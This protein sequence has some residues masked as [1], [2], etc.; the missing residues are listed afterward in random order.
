MTNEER[1]EIIQDVINEI[2]TQ[3]TSIDELPP[4][5]SISN[6]ESLPAYKRG[7][8]ELV[9]VPLSLISKPAV[10]AAASATQ[11]AE[12]ATL[13]KQEADAASKEA[14]EATEA[15][16]EATE[17]AIEASRTV[18]E[19]IETITRIETTA[20]SAKATADDNSEKLGGLSLLPISEEDYGNL[21]NEEKLDT[22]LF[23]C[24]EEEEQ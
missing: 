4:A 17:T 11:A 2:V 24:Y 20:N 1:Q 6:V 10:D 16:N 21:P 18:L 5:E 15:A 13:A 9:S 23:L 14:V 8:S 12:A 7:T 19:Q 3:S 22:T